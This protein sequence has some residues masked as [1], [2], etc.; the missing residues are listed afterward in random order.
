MKKKSFRK[1]L[2][3]SDI[4]IIVFAFIGGALLYFL[5]SAG[6]DKIVP[7]VSATEQYSDNKDKVCDCVTK[8]EPNPI[9]PGAG[10]KNDPYISSSLRI[11]ISFKA[12][13]T[14]YIT[15]ENE[16]GNI[17]YDYYQSISNDPGHIIPIVFAQAGNHQLIIKV[18]GNNDATDGA[19]TELYFRVGE[20]PPIIP[21]IPGVPSTGAYIYIGGYAVQTYS[22]L[23]SGVI[24]AVI[25]A[26]LLFIYRRRQHRDETSVKA[27]VKKTK[28][29]KKTSKRS[30]KK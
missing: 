7:T 11:N 20:L 10:T 15:I 14:G 30:P 26:I 24:V 1:Y 8:F 18:N 22:L 21:N 25:A 3:V 13:T 27:F 28:P 17:L 6:V 23:A 19:N 29:R 2:H 12:S 5:I 4:I 16:V 9:L